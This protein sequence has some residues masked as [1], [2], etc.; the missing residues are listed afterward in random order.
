MTLSDKYRTLQRQVITTYSNPDLNGVLDIAPADFGMP[1]KFT[2]WRPGQYGAV[3]SVLE[4]EERFNGICAPTGWGKSLFYMA[5]AKL[6]GKRTVIL[7][8]TKGLQDQLLEDFNAISTDIRGMA[9][10]TCPVAAD[11]DLP[12]GTVV[13]DAPCQCGYS[14]PLRSGGCNYFDVFNT[15]CSADIVVTNYQC[16]MYDQR[17]GQKGFAATRP[18][19]IL[20]LDEAHDAPEQ[21]ASYLQTELDRNECLS[22][23]I[24]WPL[25]GYTNDDW[26]LW[27]IH[28]RD[29]FE[30]RIDELTERIK[31]G[32][33]DRKRLLREVRECRRIF[34]RL[35]RVA[36][37]NDDWIVQEGVGMRSVRFDPLWPKRYAE[38]AL[39]RRVPKV[40]LVSATLRPKTAMLLGVPTTDSMSFLEFNSSFPPASRPVIHVPTVRMNW[41]NERDDDKMAWWLRKL[42]LI[43]ATRGDRKGIIHTV[44]YKRARFILDNS[45]Y[46]SRMMIHGS[47]DRRWLIERFKSAPMGAILLSPSVG[48]GYDFIGDLAEYQIISKLPFP[49]TRDQVIKERSRQDPDYQPYLVAQTLQQ[50]TGRIVR[51]EWDRGETIILDDNVQWFVKRYKSHFNRW[52]LQAYSKWEGTAPPP[53][54]EK[55]EVA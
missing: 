12:S 50:M 20:V 21:L 52:W 40:V 42:D 47:A 34:R 46:A 4:S 16:W 19:D 49:D 45:K 38:S 10:Y 14:C 6:S 13:N 32:E 55:L 27:G 44:S 11:F 54:L 2:A 23:G 8:S 5:M 30:E 33:G 26:R 51:S 35:Q 25:S 28:W 18:V 41:R 17:R 15:A 9:N 29:Q 22:L 24:T 1:D 39:F 53:P 43:L 31:L 7:T 3:N 37:V 48:T 36:V